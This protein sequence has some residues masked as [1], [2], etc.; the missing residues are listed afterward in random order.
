MS[1]QDVDGGP[2]YYAR[3]AHALPSAASYFPIGVWFES[4]TSQADVD[5]DRDV[6]LNLYVAVT[7]NPEHNLVESSTD[8][9]QSLRKIRLSGPQ[10]HRKV[11]VSQVGIITEEGYGGQG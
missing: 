5:K 9:N 6:G 8:N 4:V 2:N 1:L 7:A 10:D 11:T 3:F